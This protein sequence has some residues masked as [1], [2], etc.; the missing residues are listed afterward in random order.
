MLGRGAEVTVLDRDMFGGGGTV[1]ERAER[2]VDIRDEVSR[3][4][5]GLNDG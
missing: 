3:T 2:G 1:G 5:V 4:G